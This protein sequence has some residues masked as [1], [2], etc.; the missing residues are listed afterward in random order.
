MLRFVIPCFRLWT[1]LPETPNFR[2]FPNPRKSNSDFCAFCS[3]AAGQAPN[4][5]SSL[6]TK[7]KPCATK[8]FWPFTIP[9]LW[10]APPDKL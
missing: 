7:T 9:R 1:G 8:P 6:L 2:P 10:T 5:P 4:L 3:N